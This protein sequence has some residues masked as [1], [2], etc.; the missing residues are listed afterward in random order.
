MIVVEH[1]HSNAVERRTG[2]EGEGAAA[3][4]AA[5]GDGRREVGV[6]RGG[7][8]MGYTMGKTEGR[9]RDWQ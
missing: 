9:D 1:P 5:A 3:A 2:G 6:D 4:A 7:L 8:V